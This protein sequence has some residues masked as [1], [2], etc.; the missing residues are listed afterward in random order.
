[1]NPTSLQA[2][3]T[4]AR[5][6]LAEA[7]R[8]VGEFRGRES[9]K[10][11]AAAKAR[12]VA[13]GTGNR[14]VSA[15]HLREAGLREREAARAAQD[16]DSWLRRATSYQREILT[17]QA[18]VTRAE[19]AERETLTGRLATT[20][21]RMEQVIRELRAPKPEKLRILMLAAS[22]EG[23]LRIGREATRIRAA[24]ERA[25]HRDLVEIDL[26][27]SATTGDL[28]DGLARF[29]PHVV[30]FSGHSGEDLI[31]FEYDTDAFHGGAVVSAGAFARALAAT[32]APPLLVLL[33]SCGS[34]AQTPGLVAEVGPFA[35]GMS[36]SV[37]DQDAITYAAQFYAAVANGQSLGSAH[38]SGRSAIE[39]AGLPGHD[40]P[41]LDH[42][43]DVDPYGT[44]LVTPP[45]QQP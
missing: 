22:A 11:G 44:F 9:A 21:A 29:R 34:A 45:E 35:I 13:A 3:L 33:N 40:L 28:L 31:V 17:L 42:R 1:M 39:L 23:D 25:L 43:A 30:H 5:Q 12:A 6:R 32:D 15:Q 24:V 7:E 2:Q 27:P 10:R 16:A 38:A 36:D 18:Q 41:T 4:L 8:M 19:G 20:E 37:A 14:L 26:R